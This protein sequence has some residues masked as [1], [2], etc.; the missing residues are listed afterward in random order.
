MTVN[1]PKDVDRFTRPFTQTHKSQIKSLS[2]QIP[3]Y[4]LNEKSLES[5]RKGENWKMSNK[6]KRMSERDNKRKLSIK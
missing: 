6:G 2:N 5:L 3:S 4:D 1:L